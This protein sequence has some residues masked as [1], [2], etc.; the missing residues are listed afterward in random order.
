LLTDRLWG[1]S[2]FRQGPD[3]D[4]LVQIGIFDIENPSVEQFSVLH[5]LPHPLFGVDRYFDKDLM[6]LILNETSSNTVL[7]VNRNGNVPHDGQSLLTIGLGTV[8]NSESGPY[9]NTLQELEVNEIPQ[10]QCERSTDGN[11]T[12]QGLLT[13]NM[14]CAWKL[15]SGPCYKDSG[16]PLIVQGETPDQDMLIG[17]VSWYVCCTGRFSSRR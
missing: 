9:P 5:Y 11:F 12:F 13:D 4:F 7:K 1:L 15:N 10:D 2:Y 8:N 3:S 17:T 6:L 14:V 16:G